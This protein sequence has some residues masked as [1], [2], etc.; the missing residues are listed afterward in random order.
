QQTA[1][2]IQIV[3]TNLLFDCRRQIVGIDL[4]SLE[5]KAPEIVSFDRHAAIVVD[6]GAARGVATTS[7]P[8]PSPPWRWRSVATA[9]SRRGRRYRRRGC[10]AGFRRRRPCRAPSSLCR[11]RT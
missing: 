8:S 3:P 1:P 4:T 10:F 9:S 2:E 6:G 5:H 11:G 7:I